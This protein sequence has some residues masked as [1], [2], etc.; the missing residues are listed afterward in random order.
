MSG[1]SWTTVASVTVMASVGTLVTACVAAILSA[2]LGITF[3]LA[4]LL[5]LVAGVSVFLITGS[6]WCH[7]IRKRV[8]TLERR[9]REPF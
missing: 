4:L 6:V 9:T 8:E 2:L 5:L 7:S 1:S 3:E